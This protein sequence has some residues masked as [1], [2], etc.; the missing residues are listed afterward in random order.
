[1]QKESTA[2]HSFSLKKPA[3]LLLLLL[4]ITSL[5]YAQV[6]TLSGTVTDSD[7]RETLPGATILVKGTATGTVTDL[8]GIY[9][10]QVPQGPLTLVFS[11]VGYETLE[12]SVVDQTLVDASL[13][14][15]NVLLDEVVVIGYGTIRKSDLTGSVASVKAEDIVKI[16]SSNPVQSLQGRVSGVQVTSTS[17]TPGENP[18]VR[19]RGVGTFNNTS[20]I[21]VVD[22]VILDD[23]SFLNPSDISSMEVLKDASATAIYGSR[24]ANGVIMV[25]TKSG[26]AEEGKT[27]FNFT[28]EVGIQRVAKMIGLLDGR[29][30]AIISNEIK[31][32]SFNNVDAV[33]NTDW[34]DLV[35]DI[36]PIQNY[37]LSAS[38][39]SKAMSYYVGIGYFNQKGIIEK[40]SYKKM[41]TKFNSTFNL[42]DFLKLGTNIS[43]TPFD[44]QIAPN[45][46]YQV[47]RAQPVL[48]PYYADGTYG[49]VYNVGNPL[50]DLANSNNY[51]SGVRGV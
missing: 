8:D 32:G 19:I 18:T 21:Y 22:G 37:Q 27:V 10:L 49:V 7:S 28:G 34:Q 30:F 25:T 14:S 51:R 4:G 23:I 29:E 11:Y 40:S 5:T 16:T 12:I 6:R 48:E 17:G 35:F 15:S 20:P 24:G 50:A 39:A 33:P 13:T 44:Q 31:T 1:M 9:T 38:G 41:T 45:V 46:T 42:T 36:A 26:Q 43:I 2:F 3:L 47:Y